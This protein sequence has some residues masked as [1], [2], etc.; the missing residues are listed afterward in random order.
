M[1]SRKLFLIAT[2]VLPF[3]LPAQGNKAG[4]PCGYEKTIMPATI[5]KV[6]VYDSLNAEILFVLHYQTGTD[7]LSYLHEFGKFATQQLIDQ[8][9]LRVGNAVSYEMYRITSGHCSP[10]HEKLTLVKYETQAKKE[11]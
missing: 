8:Y 7:T 6:D 5:I 2:L 9:D 3:V 1:N 11:E 10:H 4:G